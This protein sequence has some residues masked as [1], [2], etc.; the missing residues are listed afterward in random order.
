MIPYYVGA[1]L[2]VGGY[3]TM[4]LTN[5]VDFL[6]RTI[7]GEARGEGRA[8]MEAVASVIMNRVR[9]TRYPNSVAGVVLQEWQFSTWDITDPNRIKIMT[10]TDADPLFFQAKEIA[11]QA[12]AGTLPDRTGGAL[13]YHAKSVKPAWAA[14][15]KISA[16]IG[17]HLFYTG[18]A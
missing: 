4:R 3:L 8:G 10:V 11:R 14:T 18:V 7:Y 2:A 9:S 5:D 1:A 6:A 16:V 12:V 15:G 17:N 13:H